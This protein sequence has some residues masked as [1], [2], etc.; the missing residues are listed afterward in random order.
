MVKDTDV[1]YIA[2]LKTTSLHTFVADKRYRSTKTVFLTFSDS[3]PTVKS[4]MDFG[5][6][7]LMA[8]GKY[9]LEIEENLVYLCFGLV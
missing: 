7:T 3:L 2:L 8:L 9:S 5:E 6:I 1:V 4:N